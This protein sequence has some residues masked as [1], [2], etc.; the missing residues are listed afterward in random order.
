MHFNNF[1]LRHRTRRYK[2]KYAKYAIMV[3]L[4]QIDNFKSWFNPNSYAVR[5][6]LKE[7]T[8]W[9]NEWREYLKNL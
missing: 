5:E 9:L 2:R 6:Y 8:T 3:N 1:I 7:S 4:R